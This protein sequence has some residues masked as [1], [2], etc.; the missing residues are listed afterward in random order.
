LG[1]KVINYIELTIPNY[2]ISGKEP[3]F[4]PRFKTA[5]EACASLIDSIGGKGTWDRNPF[6]FCYSF[7][8]IK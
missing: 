8:L 2:G 3:D 1:A 4:R 7:K 6:V 5:I